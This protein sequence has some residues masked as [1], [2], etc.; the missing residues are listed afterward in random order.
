VFV[1]AVIAWLVA[2][3]VVA[4]VPFAL[5]KAAIVIA[6]AF[7]YMQ[8]RAT[9]N[10]ALAIGATWLV[11]A[12]VTEMAMSAHLHHPWYA[13]LGP[14]SHP[15][16]RMLLLIAWV[17]APALFARESEVDAAHRPADRG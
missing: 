4:A 3:I 6:A 14:P 5:A 2:A 16:M 7:A 1:R 15:A 17:A 11:L 9:L 10:H 13:L 8:R 12:V